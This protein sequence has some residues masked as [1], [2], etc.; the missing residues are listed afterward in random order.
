MPGIAYI[1][2]FSAQKIIKNTGAFHFFLTFTW[3]TNGNI[4]FL[5][6]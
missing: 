4:V 6:P 3:K 2:I 1:M 5:K